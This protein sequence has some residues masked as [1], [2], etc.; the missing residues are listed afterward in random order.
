VKHHAGY[1]FVRPRI[2]HHELFLVLH[3]S[4]DVL[5]QEVDPVAEL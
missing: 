3:H 1:V 2:A 5:K 4:R